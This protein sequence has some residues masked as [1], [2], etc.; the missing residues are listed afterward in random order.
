M[1]LCKP[2][3]L[4]HA[5]KGTKAV[6]YTGWTNHLLSVVNLR[7]ELLT[8]AREWNQGPLIVTEESK[9]PPDREAQINHCY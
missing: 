4:L 5:I 8:T 1:F 6:F 3:K 2:A 7:A 9:E